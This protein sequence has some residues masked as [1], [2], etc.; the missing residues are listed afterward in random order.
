[1]EE[2]LVELVEY[3]FMLLAYIGVPVASV[4]MMGLPLILLMLFLGFLLILAVAVYIASAIPLHKMAKR[5]GIPYA[6]LAWVPYGN[7]YI[8]LVLCKREFNIFNWVKTYDRTKVFWIYLIVVFA[9]PAALGLLGVIP[10]V[11]LIISLLSPILS[12]AFYAA[13]IIFNWRVH[14]DLLM[15]YGMQENAMLLSVLSCFVPFMALILLYIM[16]KK[17]P[18]YNI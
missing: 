13:L 6:W 1:M 5:A 10:G 7:M 12:M 8:M 14:Y 17:E 18:N 2:S 16:M 9:W 11:N 3:L 4:A 15:T